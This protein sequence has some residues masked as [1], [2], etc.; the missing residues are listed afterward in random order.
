ML[1]KIIERYFN[2]TFNS[3]FASF[4]VDSV[5][6]EIGYNSKET[7]TKHHEDID[8][9]IKFKNCNI[10]KDIGQLILTIKLILVNGNSLI[11][12]YSVR[13]VGVVISQKN[14]N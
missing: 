10:I 11:Q 12:V 8:G 6:K 14:N 5:L 9:I 3:V 1:Q 13:N 4:L 7:K 2:K